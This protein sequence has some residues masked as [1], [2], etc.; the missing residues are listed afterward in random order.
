MTMH[1]MTIRLKMQIDFATTSYFRHNAH[2]LK[3]EVKQ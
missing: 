1:G 2:I 3:Y